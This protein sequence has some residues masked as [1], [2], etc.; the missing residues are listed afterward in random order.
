[1]VFLLAFINIC[2]AACGAFGRHSIPRDR[3]PPLHSQ[4]E[5]TFTSPTKKLKLIK[6][7]HVFPHFPFG[8]KNESGSSTKEI[9]RETNGALC[10]NNEVSHFNPILHCKFYGNYRLKYLECK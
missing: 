4:N 1:M 7:Y 5:E 8:A 6:I 9:D 10:A 2:R 3:H